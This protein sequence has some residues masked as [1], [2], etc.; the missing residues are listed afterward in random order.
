M[1][2]QMADNVVIGQAIAGGSSVRS[3][4]GSGWVKHD[5]VDPA[6]DEKFDTNGAGTFRAPSR[7]PPAQINVSFIFAEPR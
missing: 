5:D 2:S 4:G 6:S 1:G 7:Q 3:W